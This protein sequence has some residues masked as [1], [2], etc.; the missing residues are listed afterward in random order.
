MLKKSLMI[1]LLF[2]CQFV[3]A[4]SINGQ[5]VKYQ[6][7]NYWLLQ[8]GSKKPTIILLS[9]AGESS[10]EWNAVIPDLSKLSSV[11]AYDR[12]GL[13]KS[14]EVSDML[15]PRTA[16]M[17]VDN[18]R[19]LL[20]ARHVAPPYV[21]VSSGLAS[22]YARYFAR[23][24]PDDVKAMVLINPDVNA[25]IALGEIK[26]YAHGQGGEQV[27]FRE[28]YRKNR[29]NLQNQL[30]TKVKSAGRFHPTKKQASIITENLEQLGV[31]PS[32][33]Q[34]IASPPLKPIPVIIMEGKQDS[35]LET[36]MLKQILGETPKGIYRYK[37]LGS[38]KLQK[39]AP[40]EIVA[41]VKQVL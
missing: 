23:N 35:S 33:R 3:M 21:L 22:S 19:G 17:V 36:T 32:E 39:F 25:A 29:F 27:T 14:D 20:K 5:M 18:L 30:H 34:I 6:G 38:N 31:M 15:A 1:A 41:A 24:Y 11:L 13:G 4:A 26:K 8:A 28:V 7:K 16:K 2:V 40:Q 12:L 9:S 37:A 10:D